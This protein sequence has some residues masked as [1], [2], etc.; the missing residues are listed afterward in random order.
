[1]ELTAK[2]TLTTFSFDLPPSQQALPLPSI[3]NKTTKNNKNKRKKTAETEVRR[4]KKHHKKNKDDDTPR[5]FKRMMAISQG[6]KHRPGLDD[7]VKT[8]AAISEKVATETPR[9]KPGEDFRTF[10]ARV[11]ASLPIS[12]L[13]AKQQVKDGKD[14]VGIKV[15][16]TRKELKMHKLYDQWRAEEEKI[17]EQREEQKELA[18][19][20]EMDN[21]A[22]GI[23]VSSIFGDQDVVPGG[24]GGKKR[25]SRRKSNDDDPWAELKKKRG[26][27][28][29]GLNDI[30]QAPPELHRKQSKLLRVAGATVDVGSAPKTA[31]SLRRREEIE[32]NR[33]QVV[34][35]YRKIREHE[36]K[37][38]DGSEN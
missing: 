36:Q 4:T 26:E 34:E 12:G 21:E 35:A 17:Q 10:S 20:R 8:K 32:E 38:L 9:I 31:G 24:K 23:S 30:A 19:E 3:P 22:A 13:A 5:A 33:K 11:D 1:M 2:L 14:V 18:A 7:G 6:R 29:I 25:K 16:R 27:A 28:A 37:K 15:K